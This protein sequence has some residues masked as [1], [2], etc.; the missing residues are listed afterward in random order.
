MDRRAIGFMDSGVGGLTVVKEAL[1]QLPNENVIFLGDEAR[2]PYGEKS[3]KEIKKFA[4]QISRF[5]V[6]K[7][8]KTLVIACNTATAHALKLLQ[9]NLDIPVIGVIY[10]GSLTAVRSSKGR[11]IGIIATNG[12]IKSKAYEKTIKSISDDTTLFGLG[13]P[14]FIPMVEAGKDKSEED[15]KIVNHDLLPIKKDNVDTLIMGCTHYPIMRNLIQNAVGFNVHLVDP[16]VA[17]IDDLKKVLKD[18]DLINSSLNK[19]KL[20]F[21][22]TGSVHEFKHVAEEWLN[23]SIEVKHISIST[24]EEA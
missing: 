2:L 19:S 6:N 16:G 17:V 3:P 11:R 12:T 18:N 9:H 13:C 15:Q 24:L 8:I 21:Y 10:P 5:L 1:H 20:E 23:L 22:T 14:R 4:L 7:G